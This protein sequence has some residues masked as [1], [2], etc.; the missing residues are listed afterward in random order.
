M[1]SVLRRFIVLGFVLM[2]AGFVPVM[3]AEGSGP[4]PP[5]SESRRYKVVGS[6]IFAVG[7]FMSI[8]GAVGLYI[9]DRKQNPP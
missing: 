5:L 9:K 6:T 1:R 8:G 2:F 3:F 7:A 4:P